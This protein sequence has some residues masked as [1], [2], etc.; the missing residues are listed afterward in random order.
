MPLMFHIN[1]NNI[2]LLEV[3]LYWKKFDKMNCKMNFQ[4]IN[5]RKENKDS[6]FCSNHFTNSLWIMDM[7]IVKNNN[8]AWFSQCYWTNMRN[9]KLFH[10]KLKVVFIKCTNNGMY[11]LET[12]C[13]DSTKDTVACS[14]SEV[15]SLWHSGISKT[16]SIF[17]LRQN[18][19]NYR[20]YTLKHFL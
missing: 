3:L 8:W 18:L 9:H 10:C 19:Y 12:L 20:Y 7:T 11:C 6:P 1:I 2:L 4:N 14:P 15:S 5:L 17:P 16:A 13:W